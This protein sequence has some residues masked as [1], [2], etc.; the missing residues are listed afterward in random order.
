MTAEEAVE[1]VQY[2]AAAYRT[3]VSPLSMAVWADHL[4]GVSADVGRETAR[5]LA[6]TSQFMPHP[7]EF[8]QHSRRVA[9]RHRDAQQQLPH[10]TTPTTGRERALAHVAELRQLVAAAT[11][12]VASP[13]PARP[14]RPRT[15]LVSCP[16][17]YVEDGV[18]YCA[19]MSS[20]RP[21]TPEADR[22]ASDHPPADPS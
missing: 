5:D 12:R 7:S 20:T 11:P 6:G 3:E 4:R 17:C 8:L 2:L 1:I 21:S 22:A 19:G 10:T 16:Y 15:P 13:A 9:W 18:T 14:E